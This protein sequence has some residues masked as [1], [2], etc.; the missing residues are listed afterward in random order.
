MAA[1]GGDIGPR[2]RVGVA[3]Q[4]P[5]VGAR[6]DH[7]PPQRHPSTL[8]LNGARVSVGDGDQ[9]FTVGGLT[10]AINQQLRAGF[11][12]GVWVA[13]EVSGLRVSG[14]HTY[15]S[16]VEEIDGAKATLAV[17]LFANVKRTV[18][19]KLAANRVE[20]T[21]GTKVRIRGTLDVY[22]PSGRLSLKV[23]DIDPQFTLGDITAARDAVMAR[24]A[25]DDLLDRNARVPVPVMPLRVG[26]VTSIGSAAWHDFRDEI[27]RSGFG[28]HL[29]GI[30]ARV[31]GDQA[32]T[33]VAAGIATA[34][35][36]SV[37]V[38]VVIRGGGARNDLAAFDSETIARA[39]AM[40]PVPVWTGLGHEIDRTV[41]DEVAHTAHKTPT[42][43]ADALVDLVTARAQTAEALWASIASTA[44]TRVTAHGAALTNRA[45]RVAARTHQAVARSDERLRARTD[46]LARVGAVL[47][48]AEAG[49]VERA[50][51]VELLDPARL[52]ER[53]WSITTD[54]DGRPLRSTA[55]V[56]VGA[57]LTTR[58]ADGTVT[59]TV[60]G[61]VEDPEEADRDDQR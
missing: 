33:M 24:L 54:A 13:G 20:L 39:I 46:R 35:A 7:R 53:G 38:I 3:V 19:P 47:D 61:T 34:V 44:A 27:V 18:M 23:S 42:A 28:F 56:A 52:L 25:A 11:G 15:F 31:Q 9:T 36:H 55:Q 21:D 58:V 59:S 10:E 51:R 50:R 16:L 22:A 40:C 43:C 1:T 8:V 2:D 5:A 57:M 17:S 4:R 60:T 45:S 49:I 48:R 30:D 41:A 14:A 6:P 29:L 37:D 32:E 12:R 26:V